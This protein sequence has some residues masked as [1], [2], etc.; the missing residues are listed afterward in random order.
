[1]KKTFLFGDDPDERGG[2]GMTNLAFECCFVGWIA[3]ALMIMV[4]GILT[5]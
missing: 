1:M 3:V 4:W 5:S 2:T